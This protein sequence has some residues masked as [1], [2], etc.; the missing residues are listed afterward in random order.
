[1]D[2]AAPELEQSLSGVAVALVLQDR[3]GRVLLGQA[4]LQLEGGDREA[5]DEE[6]EVEGE[7][8]LVAA[9][10]ELAGDAEAVLGVS[11]GGSRVVA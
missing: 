6:G 2:D 11:L 8:G 7:L 9:V 10:P 1:M 3:I 4:V 5:V